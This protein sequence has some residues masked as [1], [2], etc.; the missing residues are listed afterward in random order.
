MWGKK[1]NKKPLKDAVRAAY[2]VLAERYDAKID[3]KPHNALYD[4][5]NTLSLIGEVAGKHVLDAACGPGKY[6]EILLEQGAKVT[7]FDFSPKMVEL[8]KKRN[9]KA[10]EFFVHDLSTPLDRFDDAS[11]DA[12]LCALAMHY[13]EDWDRVFKEFNRVL[14]PGGQIVLSIEHPFFCY[15]YFKSTNYFEIEAVKATWSGFGK[16]VVVDS[17]RRSLH[18]CM[19]PILENGFVIDAFIE[20]KPLPEF[21]QSDPKHYK[22]LMAFPAFLCLR[23]RKSD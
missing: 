11:F 2:E 15:G 10:G 12:V 6:A 16:K 14:R 7:G 18:D 8:A 23:A 1:A 13:I 17:Y 21:K 3:T 22:E 9:P 20:P 4:R 19:Q 5:P